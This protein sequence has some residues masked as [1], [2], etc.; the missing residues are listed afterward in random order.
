M[1]VRLNFGYMDEEQVVAEC[2]G[3]LKLAQVSYE[4]NKEEDGIV[5]VI[6]SSPWR[7]EIKKCVERFLGD[8]KG[9]ADTLIDNGVL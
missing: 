6:L 5:S 4:V 9:L 3:Y 2:E 7:F 1:R 8:F